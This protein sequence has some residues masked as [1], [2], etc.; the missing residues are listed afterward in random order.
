MI[1]QPQIQQRLIPGLDPDRLIES[2]KA[3]QRTVASVCL[4]SGGHDSVVLAHRCQ[5]HY[6]SLAF[7]DT[8][9]ALPGVRTFV[10]EFAAWLD[11]P[12]LVLE[13]G[14]AYRRLVLGT[15]KL[16]PPPDWRPYGFPGP[17]GHNLAY[18]L[19][20]ECQLRRLR[21]QLQADHLRQRVL[22]L[23]GIRRSESKRRKARP[24]M[25]RHGAIVFVSPLIDWDNGQ[26]RAYRD[27]H[28]LPES[29][30]SA[31][32]HRSG[33]CN[34]GA[35]APHGEREMLRSLWPSWFEQTIASLEREAES[36]GIRS[37]VWGRATEAVLDVGDEAK[38]PLC[39]S[40]QLQLDESAT[41]ELKKETA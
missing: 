12:L 17:A 22:M 23:S 4:C 30:V 24:A 37:C 10:E 8:G 14:D 38:R 32:L 6:D 5:E 25:S 20:K 3:E 27:Q 26:M 2:T 21:A 33:E 13:A 7:I 9:T 16:N 11:K 39:S 15:H 1:M 18:D 31:L 41:N 28:R 29:D 34:C 35:F 40:C 19:L 36:A